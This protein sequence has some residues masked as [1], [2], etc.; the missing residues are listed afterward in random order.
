MMAPIF[1][2]TRIFGLL[3]LLT[4]GV[5]VFAQVSTS[6]GMDMLE[7]LV[8]EWQYEMHLAETEK[9]GPSAR[10]ITHASFIL[11]GRFL[12]LKSTSTEGPAIEALGLLG[13]DGR[14]VKGEYFLLSLDELS[15]NYVTSRGFYLPE[16]DAIILVGNEIDPTTTFEYTFETVLAFQDR[17]R[18]EIEYFSID[19][20]VVRSEVASIAYR[21]INSEAMLDLATSQEIS[22]MSF[23]VLKTELA[24]VSKLRSRA[25][26]DDRDREVVRQVFV[27]LLSR[28]AGIA[29]SQ[30]QAEHE[31]FMHS[32]EQAEVIE[33]LRSLIHRHEGSSRRI[34]SE[35]IE[36]LN[37]LPR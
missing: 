14:A 11:G 20:D 33:E 19:P 7:P 24:R 18:F 27:K 6:A 5:Q 2:Y 35:M 9:S 23:E 22:D 37:E 34:R 29:R 28:Y 1:I 26:L 13:F 21:R 25:D 10:G 31:L 36:S 15:S 4:S 3:F 30:A 17:N 16:R 12:E 8:G 32:Q